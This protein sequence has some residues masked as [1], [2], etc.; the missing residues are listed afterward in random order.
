M[1]FLP[2]KSRSKAVR[3]SD[4]AREANV[5][6][7]TVSRVLSG[8]SSVNNKIHERIFEVARNLGYK[9][10]ERTVGKM[11]PSIAMLAPNTSSF[12]HGHPFFSAIIHGIQ[13][14][15][16]KHNYRFVIMTAQK[17]YEE[18]PT[19]IQSLEEA[20]ISGVI[21]IDTKLNDEYAAGL[22]QRGFPFV[23]VGRILGMIHNYYVDIDN[24]AGVYNAISALIRMGHRRIGYIT[25]NLKTNVGVERLEGY[26]RA[27]IDHGLGYDE[28]LIGQGGETQA[29]AYQATLDLLSRTRV[30]LPTA[31]GVFNDFLALAV[32]KALKDNGLRVPDDVSIIGFDDYEFSAFTDP[33]LSTVRQ[34]IA[35]LGSRAAQMLIDILENRPVEKGQILLPTELVMRE[36]VVALS[37][38]SENETIA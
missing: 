33:P 11:P 15:T 14:V 37:H 36:S 9:R 1:R 25:G 27:M 38:P 32:M 13:Q 8:N 12:V 24:Y 30:N 23:V 19:Q 10:H 28:S 18:D 29:H 6:I 4:I 22:A 17:P 16:D 3:L 21:L 26:K 5:S 7:A 20:G 35:E 2:G 34:P 31:L